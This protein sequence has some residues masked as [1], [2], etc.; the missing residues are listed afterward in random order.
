M[1]ISGTWSA[2]ALLLASLSYASAQVTVEVTQEQQQI[3]SGEALKAAVRIT[4]LVGPNVAHGRG[5]GLADVRDRV[6]RWSG[7]A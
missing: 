7:G 1:K 6:A 3:V 4:N 5:A 2:V